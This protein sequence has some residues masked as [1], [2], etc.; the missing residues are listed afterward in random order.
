RAGT[1]LVKQD[2]REEEIEERGEPIYAQRWV[3]LCEEPDRA[4]ALED[5][6]ARSLPG[7]RC[8]AV[9][10]T[11][12]G[13]AAR[14][15]AAVQQILAGLQEIFETRPRSDVLVQV[16]TPASGDGAVFA[17][18]S[19]LLRTARLEQPKLI[20]QI[21][22]FD[23]AEPAAGVVAKLREN[24]GAPQ[25]EEVRYAGGERLVGKWSEVPADVNDE[26]PWRD[27]GVYL[28]TGGA[29]GLGLIF[30]K[31]IAEQAKDTVLVLTGRSELTEAKQ[32]A[33]ESLQQLGAR[34][35]YRRVDVSDRAAVL[36]LV[37]GIK[38]Q[39]G[40]LTGIVHGAGVLR[41]S[42]IMNKTAA[43]ASAV[44]APKVAGVVNLDEATR[45]CALEC[46][47][48]FGSASGAFGNVGQADYAAANG[49]L[50][51]YASY[52]NELMRAG[53]RRGRTLSID[54]P[55]WQDG[56]MQVDAAVLQAQRS[57]GIAPLTTANG[58][59]A[60][61]RANGAAASR[62]V[63]MSGEVERLR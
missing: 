7:S 42:F 1:L 3:V 62:V 17:G 46:M 14:Y 4:R 44:I 41:D 29:G 6:I 38:E 22:G 23:A 27:G 10:M 48:L 40:G 63:V 36:E 26:I 13:I 58:L 39:F 51:A 16:V 50:D 43:D 25:D 61:Y 12:G 57:R 15:E 54:W 28:L 34:V 19:G 37:S 33:L 56:G 20:G 9:D 30:A 11:A 32:A 49:F 31:E 59:A 5:E 35:V 60:F 53:R 47:I 55:L 21:I 52:R 24:A 8:V 45:D 2:W 18:L